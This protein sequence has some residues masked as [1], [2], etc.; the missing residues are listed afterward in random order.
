MATRSSSTGVTELI[1]L[2]STANPVEVWATRSLASSV[3]FKRPC[4]F[5]ELWKFGSIMIR[6]TNHPISMNFT[7][8]FIAFVILF[9]I[10][11]LLFTEPL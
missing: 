1:A 9:S 7:T 8:W 11:L 2:E 3:L 4:S 5:K 6:I 10:L